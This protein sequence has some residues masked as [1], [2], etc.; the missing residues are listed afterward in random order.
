MIE[1]NLNWTKGRGIILKIG[2]LSGKRGLGDH[3]EAMWEEIGEGRGCGGACSR[4]R[5]LLK[6]PPW[7]WCRREQT[8]PELLNLAN[9]ENRKAAWRSISWG[10][11]H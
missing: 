8:A 1:E 9:V 5:I 6:T 3:Q 2:S 4:E 10:G 11:V 7:A